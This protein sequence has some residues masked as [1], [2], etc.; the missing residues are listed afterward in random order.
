MDGVPAWRQS[1]E[2]WS[3]KG[4]R[5]YREPEEAEVPREPQVLFFTGY[6]V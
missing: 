4:G 6:L 1:L 3:N 5:I 2:D